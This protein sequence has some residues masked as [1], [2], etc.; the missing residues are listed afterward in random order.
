MSQRVNYYGVAPKAI[1]PMLKVAAPADLEAAGIEERVQELV[2]IRASQINGCTYCLHMHT[3]DALKSGERPERIFVL[4]GWRE[5][6][7][8][9]PRERAA[10][11]WTEAL[12]RLPETGAPDADFAGLKP[13]FSDEQIVWLTMLIGQINTW[14]RIAVGFRAEHPNDKRLARELEAAA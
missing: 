12:T 11:A 6:Q 8:F 5:S 13:H 1:E 2:K 4:D 14:N 7:A 10:L 9:T 3:S